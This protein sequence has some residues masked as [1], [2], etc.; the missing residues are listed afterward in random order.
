MSNFAGLSQDQLLG[1]GANI[2]IAIVILIVAHFAAKAVKWAIAKAVDRI[3]FF[4]RRENVAGA[5][6]QPPTKVGE[7]VGEVASW[8]V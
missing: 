7:R 3:G 4:P 8:L 2:F 5:S 6:Q 1:L